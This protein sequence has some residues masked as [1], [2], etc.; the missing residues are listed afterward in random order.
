MPLEWEQAIGPLAGGRGKRQHS[1]GTWRSIKGEIRVSGGELPRRTAR[2]LFVNDGMIRPSP[3]S[4]ILWPA[5]VAL[6]IGLASLSNPQETPP[7]GT[8][9]SRLLVGLGAG[10]Q[11]DTLPGRQTVC[12]P[13]S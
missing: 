7:S 6:L 3:W 8:I 11:F 1:S 13:G 2:R 12:C 10:F 5:S 9:S 4:L